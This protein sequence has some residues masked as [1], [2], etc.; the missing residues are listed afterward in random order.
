M[1]KILFNDNIIP[2]ITIQA[3]SGWRF[4]NWRELWH[5]KDLFYFL[6]W[7]DLKALYAQSVMGLGWA[8]IQPVGTMLIFTTVF[9][10]LARIPSD[11]VPYA[12][13]S[14]TGLV[15]WLYFASA[16]SGASSSLVANAGILSKVYFPRLILPLVP[17]VG[18]LVN[19]TV[20]MVTLL[21]LM[22]WFQITP[23]LWALVLPFLIIL[24]ILTA[25][26]M[27]IWFTALAVQYRDVN[28]GI[29]FVTQIMMYAS[30]VIYPVSLVPS[31]YRLLYGLNPMAGII[32]GFRCAL[33]GTNSMPWDL[34]LVGT[35]VAI[36]L[37]ITGIFY[38]R[39]TE[40]IFADVA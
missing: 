4:I 3:S 1:K 25:T 14:Y 21:A 22:V 20:A 40:R 9:G 16:L 7:R 24:I 33:L 15:P 32:E 38:F 18:Q 12:I 27:G 28:H 29:G 5:Y 10:Y 31:Q 35:V 30:P 39:R 36:T 11:G 23:T 2:E 34:L 26:G 6:V 37:V 13:F 19:F 8:I 17:I